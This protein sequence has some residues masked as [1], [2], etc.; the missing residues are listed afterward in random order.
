MSKPA[1]SAEQVA[2][3][4]KRFLDENPSAK[5]KVDAIPVEVAKA[6]GVDLSELRL[7]KTVQLLCQRVLSSLAWKNLNICFV[8]Q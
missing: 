8:S 3:G 6:L 1:L 5:A 2:I 4:R 7:E